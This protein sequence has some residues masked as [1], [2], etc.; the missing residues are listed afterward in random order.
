MLWTAKVNAP[1]KN[2]G[3][4]PFLNTVTPFGLHGASPIP[5][6]LGEDMKTKVIAMA[7]VKGGA[8]RS[9]LA[10]TL[11]GELSKQG[12]TVLIDADKRES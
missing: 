5:Q 3:A 8:G 1:T 6:A 4:P 9:T 10:T 12:D 11:A 2:S 7:Q